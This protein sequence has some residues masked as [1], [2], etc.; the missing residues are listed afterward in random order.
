MLSQCELH[1]VPAGAGPLDYIGTEHKLLYGALVVSACPACYRRL[2]IRIIALPELRLLDLIEA[3]IRAASTVL[4]GQ[5]ESTWDT[6]TAR[7]SLW[8]RQLYVAM[9]AVAR[10]IDE[11][12][13]EAVAACQEKPDKETPA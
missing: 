3:E 8:N 10:L 13:H 11:M 5:G 1:H 6:L 9:E 7:L 12:R 2:Q 4:R